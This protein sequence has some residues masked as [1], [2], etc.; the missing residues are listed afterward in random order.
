MTWT[1]ISNP[2][3]AGVWGYLANPLQNAKTHD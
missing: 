3:H 1:W 2:L